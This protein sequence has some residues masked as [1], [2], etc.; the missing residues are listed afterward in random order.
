M[1][2]C[3][4]EREE[5]ILCS[6]YGCQTQQHTIKYNIESNIEV[7]TR[8]EEE[9]ETEHLGYC[10]NAY[11]VVRVRLCPHLYNQQSWTSMQM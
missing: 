1:A 4:T 9:I 6:I 8:I 11:G 2:V 7:A 5:M 10:N 3:I